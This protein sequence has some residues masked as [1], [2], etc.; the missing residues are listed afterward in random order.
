MAWPPVQAAGC[1]A[2]RQAASSVPSDDFSSAVAALTL[3]AAASFA[4]LEAANLFV[5]LPAGFNAVAGGHAAV[6]AI[7]FCMPP[8]TATATAYNVLGGH[9]LAAL[10]GVAQLA[11]LPASLAFAS[12][13]LITVAIVLAMK[14]FDAVHPPAAAFGFLAVA[15]NKG[16]V[17]A[18]GPLLGCAVLI[19]CQQLWLQLP[20]PKA[21]AA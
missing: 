7:L 18:V 9:A 6:T 1:T 5:F 21:K 15:G 14:S 4:T 16:L 8:K 12:K 13:T 2:G 10:A 11:A 19:A 20:G 3:G 17:D